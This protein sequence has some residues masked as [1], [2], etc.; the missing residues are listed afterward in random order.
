MAHDFSAEALPNRPAEFAAQ[1]EEGVHSSGHRLLSIHLWCDTG[2][3]LA[4]QQQC[5]PDQNHT[6]PAPAGHGLADTDRLLETTLRPVQQHWLDRPCWLLGLEAAALQCLTSVQELMVSISNCTRQGQN[7]D[8][9]AS[10]HTCAM[11]L[12]VGCLHQVLL[13]L[14]QLCPHI[15]VSLHRAAHTCYTGYYMQEMLQRA[16]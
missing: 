2:A 16:R 11:R 13:A 6:P 15:C 12:L 3:L 1:T 5:S 4:G 9:I 10:L 7:S 14:A 8:A